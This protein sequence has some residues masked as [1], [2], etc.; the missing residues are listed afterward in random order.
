[1]K[2]TNSLKEFSRSATE[3]ERDPGGST[4]PWKFYIPVEVLQFA[5]VS[6]ALLQKL[7]HNPSESRDFALK[8]STGC[9]SSTGGA[10]CFIDCLSLHVANV[11]RIFAVNFP[12]ASLP[13]PASVWVFNVRCQCVGSRRG[14]RRGGSR[15]S[16]QMR[17]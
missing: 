17:C 3:S 13:L 16:V 7:F 8:A 15:G 4:A 9:R 1:M 10:S 5:G 14:R 12:A 2:L 11:G 6:T